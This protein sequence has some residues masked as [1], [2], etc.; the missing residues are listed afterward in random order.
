MRD[1]FQSIID[2]KLVTKFDLSEMTVNLDNMD[3]DSK[4]YVNALV[5][6]GEQV[7]TFIPS[8]S[9]IK[10]KPAVIWKLLKEIVGKDL[11]K[12]SMPVFINE[13]CSILQKAAEL[14]F[15]TDQL[16]QASKHPEDSCLRMAYVAITFMG[17]YNQVLGRLQKPFNPMLGETYELVTPKFRYL[18]EMVCHHPPI[19]AFNCEGDGF[20]AFRMMETKQRF[21]GKCVTVSDENETEITIMVNGGSEEKYYVKV[22]NLIVGN[23]VIG[24]RFVE[25][26]GV[27]SIVNA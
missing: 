7:R 16:T 12:F 10:I 21:N 17:C 18:S 19:T 20:K 14:M 6:E 13:P 27:G 15:C 26:Q 22:P 25:P 24:E 9:D 5:A 23:L 1:V 2:E 8:T 4:A 11:S 3:K